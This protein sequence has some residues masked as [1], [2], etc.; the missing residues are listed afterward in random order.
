[1]EARG[2]QA[3]PTCGRRAR[4]A[5]VRR[6]GCGVAPWGAAAPCVAAGS[7]QDATGVTVA[8][9]ER[10]NGSVWRLQRA[11]ALRTSISTTTTG[12]SCSSAASCIAVGYF[13]QPS[14]TFAPLA[15]NWD[16]TAWTIQP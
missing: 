7:Y 16:G 4:P 6:G 3:R 9:L 8:L 13:Q 1:M 11:P 15:E 14:G 5:R 10:W 2:Q 12:V